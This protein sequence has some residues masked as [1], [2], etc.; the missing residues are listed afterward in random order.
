MLRLS[1]LFAGMLAASVCFARPAPDAS[2]CSLNDSPA[3]A[4][5]K[6]AYD[7]FKNARMYLL[8]SIVNDEPTHSQLQAAAKWQLGE[9]Q[10]AYD[11]AKAANNGDSK[12]ARK[13]FYAAKLAFLE[14]EV[15]VSTAL[16]N[17]GLPKFPWLGKAINWV[18]GK[19]KKIKELFQK[20]FG[21]KNDANKPA[22]TTT[23]S[24][25][26]KPATTA[27]VTAPVTTAP[28]TATTNSTPVTAQAPTKALEKEANRFMDQQEVELTKLD[29]HINEL[30][31]GDLDRCEL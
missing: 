15:K 20:W 14:V 24:T 13:E 23:P 27:P 5:T 17:K 30:E 21:G 25:P 9:V 31:T 3:Y 10:K 7:G 2:S 19:W 6:A 16:V 29:D 28:V 18:Q 22:A 26:S 11:Q 8:G 12:W 1:T 4:A